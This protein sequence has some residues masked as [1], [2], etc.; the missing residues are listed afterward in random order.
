[1]INKSVVRGS[2]NPNYS[3][4]YEG[5]ISMTIY[6][7]V[8]THNKTGLKYLGKTKKDPHIYKGSGKDW[9]PHIKQFGNDVTTEILKECN[10][11]KEISYWGR[12]YCDFLDI[13][14]SS[15]WANRIPETGGGGFGFSPDFNKGKNNP[16]F[17]RKR[18]DLSG[19]DSPNKSQSRRDENSIKSKIMWEMPGYRERMAGIHKQYWQSPEYRKKMAN[20]KYSV[21][22][23]SINGKEYNSLR[24]AA[25]DLNLDPSTVSKRCTCNTNEKFKDWKYL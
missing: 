3:N 1:M 11:N 25:K 5:D 12:Y 9:I 2:V 15:E 8:K 7:Y 6:L 10:N 21:K 20:R 13:T 22:R 23:V 18:P 19:E 14:N 17:G 24:E 4:I 16:M